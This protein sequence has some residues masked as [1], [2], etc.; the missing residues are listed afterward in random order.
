VRCPSGFKR[1]TPALAGGGE[2]WSRSSTLQALDL[3]PQKPPA[4]SVVITGEAPKWMVR[5]PSSVTQPVTPPHPR[6][7]GEGHALDH[8]E[9]RSAVRQ[10]S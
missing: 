7:L 9:E 1:A 5:R 8:M 4:P 2:D 3:L 6:D 10:A